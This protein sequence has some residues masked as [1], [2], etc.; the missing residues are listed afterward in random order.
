MLG[1]S[2]VMRWSSSASFSKKARYKFAKPGQKA[3]PKPAAK[4]TTVKKQ[5]G[6]EKNGGTRIVQV[7]RMSKSY[8]TQVC[9]H[10][11][12]TRKNRFRDHKRKL[13][14]SITPG[15]VLILVAGPYKGK[16]VVFLK[17]LGTGLLLISGPYILNGCPLRENK[18]KVR[19]CY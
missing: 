19:Y 18:P 6:G 15:T 14:A 8:E 16:H 4:P 13:R 12:Q 1:K 11:L 2:G 17:Q 9:P 5:I 10:R 7:K 3:P